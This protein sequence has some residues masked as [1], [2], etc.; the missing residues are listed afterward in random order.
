MITVFLIIYLLVSIGI[1][2]ASLR[3][4]AGYLHYPFWAGLIFSGFAMPQFISLANNQ[5]CPGR[6]LEKYIIMSA[7]CL[8]ATYFGFKKGSR[9]ILGS[10]LKRIFSYNMNFH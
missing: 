6:S 10:R 1:I 9:I 2:I 5:F 7:L 4:K 3:Y 8:A